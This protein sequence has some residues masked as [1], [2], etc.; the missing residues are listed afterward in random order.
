M[1]EPC[2]RFFADKTK[3]PHTKRTIKKYSPVY[4][5]IAEEC[6]A[7]SPRE[8]CKE[9]RD[10][11]T[12]NPINSKS[13]KKGEKEYTSLHEECLEYPPARSPPPRPK[14]SPSQKSPPKTF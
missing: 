12:I 9:W 5:K 13:I 2:A 6:F 1:E 11:P 4:N 14:V 7:K 8:K 3:N 10:H